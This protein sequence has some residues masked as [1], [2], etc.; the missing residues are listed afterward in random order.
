MSE[1]EQLRELLLAQASALQNAESDRLR[2]NTQL[3]ESQEEM[4]TL[5]EEREELRRMQEA[6]HVESEQQKESMKEI[7][8][9]VSLCC[10]Y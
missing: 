4:K 10:C 1:L 7:S 8:S 2:L 9:K 3:E 5:R 6:L